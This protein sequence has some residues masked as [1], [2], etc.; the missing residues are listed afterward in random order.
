M[1]GGYFE[2][3]QSR[4]DE[5]IKELEVMIKDKKYYPDDATDIPDDI[6]EH[7][8]CGLE[9]IKLARIYLQRIDWLLS[10]DDSED[11][12]KKRLEQDMTKL[13]KG[14]L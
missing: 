14:I 5:P 12:F 4:L 13:S 11:C 2:Y 1:S 3:I 6:L 7:F 9:H 8:K 10:D